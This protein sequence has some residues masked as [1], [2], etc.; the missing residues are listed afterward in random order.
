MGRIVVFLAAILATLGAVAAL[1][2]WMDPRGDRYHRRFLDAAL[3]Q[4]QPC[5]ISEEVLGSR[6]WSDFKIDLFRRT[7]RTV[8]VVGTSRV[9]G[10]TARPGETGFVNLSAPGIGPDTLPTLFR[11]LHSL[12]PQP[13]TIYLGV[14]PFWFGRWTT[15]T[16]FG[17]SLLGRLRELLSSQLTRETLH[18]LRRAPGAIRHPQKLLDAEIDQTPRGCVVDR[19][20]SVRNR[21]AGAWGPDGSLHP[22]EDVLGT[23]VRRRLLFIAYA[24]NGFVGKRLDRQQLR[25]LASALSLARSYRWRVVGVTVPFAPHSL[26]LLQRSHG[27][28]TVLARF[29]TELPRVF[30]RAGFPYLDLIDVGSV[31]CGPRDFSG[32]D[33]A[34][35]DPGCAAKIRA[36]LDAAARA[37][38][39]PA[40]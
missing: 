22:A 25:A 5:Y 23:P 8:V 6:T 34:H 20:H 40:R 33:E 28:R 12:Q 36:L 35:P 31:P 9:G 1:N 17:H 4:P 10:I 21:V 13:L 11:R 39:P 2:W 38:P 15:T 19:G 16:G 26:R 37:T 7:T 27:T 3:A 18:L 29:R 24:G 14:E 30:T 32:Q